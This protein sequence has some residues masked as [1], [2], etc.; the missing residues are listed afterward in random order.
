[1]SPNLVDP[2]ENEVV[3]Y[4]TEELTMNCCA[5]KLPCTVK[6]PVIF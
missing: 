3:I 5:T 6:F 2:L 4:D 1:V